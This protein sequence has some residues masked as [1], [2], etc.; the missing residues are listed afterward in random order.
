[1]AGNTDQ[2][3]Y[4][5]FVFLSKFE[6]M[7]KQNWKPGNMVYPLPAA[8]ISCGD[9]AGKMNL[10]T[11]SWLGTICT[12]PPMCYISVRPERY[13]YDMI[14]QSGEFVINLTTADIAKATDWCGVKSGRDH[15]KFKESG[16]TSAAATIVKCPIV[17]EAP[18]SIECKVKEIKSLG[19]HDMFIADV[20][21]IIADDRYIDPE[22]G[23]FNLAASGVMAYSHGNY[24][25][26][27]KRIGKFGWSVMKDKTKQRQKE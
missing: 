14:K 11:V 18:I 8:L 19:S 2:I 26:L 13:S 9:I 10:L 24:Y 21:N 4:R 5:I 7:A 23:A 16:L 3:T 6:T 17:V 27:G 25:S 12:D 1:M 15:D 20:V 22:T